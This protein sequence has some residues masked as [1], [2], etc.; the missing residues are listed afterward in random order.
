MATPGF[1][2]IIQYYLIEKVESWYS[3][4]HHSKKEGYKIRISKVIFSTVGECLLKNLFSTKKNTFPLQLKNTKAMKENFS[5]RCRSIPSEN[6]KFLGNYG[7]EK[8]KKN[9]PMNKYTFIEVSPFMFK[10][11]KQVVINYANNVIELT[12]LIFQSGSINKFGT[13]I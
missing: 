5:H 11:S 9:Q 6:A 4:K 8:D 7:Q 13:L 2:M 12:L 10:A 3:P 1:C